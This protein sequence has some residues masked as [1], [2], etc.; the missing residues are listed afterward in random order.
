MLILRQALPSRLST[1]GL[2]WAVYFKNTTYFSGKQCGF[3]RIVPWDFFERFLRDRPSLDRP[4][5]RRRH[6]SGIN[7]NHRIQNTTQHLAS[8][9]FFL[10]CGGKWNKP[11]LMCAYIFV[12]F[13]P[14]KKQNNILLSLR[15]CL[16]LCVY[17]YFF[18]NTLKKNVLLKSFSLHCMFAKR[19]Y[20]SLF[21]S[22]PVLC[23]CTHTGVIWYSITYT[24]ILWKGQWFNEVYDE[25]QFSSYLFS[26]IIRYH[27]APYSKEE[28]SDAAGH[29]KLSDKC[30]PTTIS[31]GL[32]LWLAKS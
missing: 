21:L 5:S 24:F 23:L 28:R 3:W 7:P 16:L 8:S 26:M 6:S 27:M 29:N 32:I 19:I 17:F 9:R 12:V 11:L 13:I 20:V 4:A 22:L 10:Y 31:L 18:K 2:H 15:I 30:L 14:K 25:L 1:T